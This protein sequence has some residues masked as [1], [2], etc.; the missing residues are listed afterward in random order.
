MRGTS[1]QTRER[2][3]QAADDLFYG[4]G[5]RSAGVDVIAARA[6]VTKRTLY[7]HF[8]SK[9]DLIA[10]YLRSRHQPTLDR[11]AAWAAGTDVAEQISAM[12]LRLEAW[13]QR[14]TWKGCPFAR[15]VAELQA[16][17]DHPALTVAAGHKGAFETWLR[18]RFIAAGVS[19]PD[20]RARQIMV[21]L[22]GAITQTLIHHDP[23]YVAAAREAAVA[24][25]A[26]SNPAPDGS[27]RQVEA[28]PSE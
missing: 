28:D 13:A 18:A 25:L 22:D 12:F 4:E 27:I 6:G 11:Y 24:L 21:L 20:I 10:A 17:P 16:W 2:I 23:R 3:L 15:A 5:I 26:S 9:D 19:D 1:S 14:A 7:Y 8:K